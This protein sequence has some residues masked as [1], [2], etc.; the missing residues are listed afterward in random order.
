M[1]SERVSMLFPVGRMVQ[2]DLY[3][4]NDTDFV[5]KQKKVYP[6]GHPKAGQPKISYFFAVAIPKNP[7]EQHWSQA[8]NP[9]TREPWGQKI[10]QY[11]HAAW[12]KG[13]AQHPSFAWKI[14]DGD[15]TRPN[16]NGRVNANTE[17]FKG[18]W[19]VG[20][21]STLPPKIYNA[22]GQ[23]LTEPGAVKRG[24]YI[25]VYGSYTSNESQGN[26]GIYINGDHV[27]LRGYGDEI[28]SG[29]DP[30]QIGF[31][32]SALPAGASATPMGGTPFPVA[33]AFPVAGGG[34]PSPAFPTP[35]MPPAAGGYGGP[36]PPPVSGAPSMGSPAFLG[37]SA[38]GPTTAAFP[39]SP[40]PTAAQQPTYVTP[41]PSFLSP[42]PPPAPPVAARQM[43]PKA[44]GATYEQFR[45]QGWTDDML[46]QQGFMA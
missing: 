33:A 16:K 32:K 45:A 17:G 18:C 20:F 5:T 44:A 37:A 14:E 4:G 1:A 43:T 24:Y 42:V 28:R 2:G 46:R 10:W 9:T 27:A 31:G 19:I 38:P 21:S 41:A 7:G 39:S 12:P 29:P 13:E 3:K 35:G 40:P 8:V 25:E 6:A 26:A 34:A 36:P 15:D 23:A 30:T 11:G 22:S